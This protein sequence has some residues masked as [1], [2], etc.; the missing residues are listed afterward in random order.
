M[1]V[2]PWV[3]LRHPDMRERA[4]EVCRPGESLR[5]KPNLQIRDFMNAACAQWKV[6]TDIK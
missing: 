3:V 4:G 2:L 5:M 1:V 6:T